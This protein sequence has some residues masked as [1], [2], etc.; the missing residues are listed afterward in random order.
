MPAKTFATQRY[1]NN[2][3]L[4]IWASPFLVLAGVLVLAMHGNFAALFI[5]GG[6]MVLGL[7]IA[8]WRDLGDRCNYTFR[9]DRLILEKK[10]SRTEIPIDELLDA[11][12]VD[13]L[14]AREYVRQRAAALAGGKGEHQAAIDGMMRYCTVDIGIT[15]F[16]F[17]L[18]RSITDRLPSARHDLVLLRARQGDLVLTPRYTQDFVETMGRLIGARRGA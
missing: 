1:W 10:G 14:A 2:T 18:G 11:S 12:L 6:I 8:L 15:T 17:G 5:A 7:A 16:T 4:V 3:L 13:R 9:S